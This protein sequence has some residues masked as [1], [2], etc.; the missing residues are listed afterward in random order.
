MNN[1]ERKNEVQ[2]QGLDTSFVESDGG[3]DIVAKYLVDNT[4]VTVRFVRDLTFEEREEINSY[5]FLGYNNADAVE[6]NPEL[7]VD[8]ELWSD[9]EPIDGE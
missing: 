4:K 6:V 3:L 2:L 9:M 5:L 7:M 8:C 1:L